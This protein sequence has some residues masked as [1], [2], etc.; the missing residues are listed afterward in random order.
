MSSLVP[1]HFAGEL[2]K[3]LYDELSSSVRGPVYRPGDAEYDLSISCNAA[4]PDLMYLLQLLLP[5]QDL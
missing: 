4:Q 1:R 3:T 5:I 2:P